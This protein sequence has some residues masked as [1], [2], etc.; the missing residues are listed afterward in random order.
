MLKALALSQLVHSS[1]GEVIA[2]LQSDI[3]QITSF[4]QQKTTAQ[5]DQNMTSYNLLGFALVLRPALLAPVTT[6]A[7]D[8]LSQLALSEAFQALDD[9]RQA[10]LEYTR[11]G[12]ALTPDIL[13]GV[14]E[15]ARWSESLQSLQSKTEEWLNNSRETRFRYEPITKVWKR[16]LNEGEPLSQMLTVVIQDDRD[17][18]QQVEQ[19]INAFSSADRVHQLLH[20][21]DR[22]IRGRIADVRAIDNAARTAVYR[23]VQNAL[24]FAQDWLDLLQNEPQQVNSFIHEQANNCRTKIISCLQQSQT[25]LQAFLQQHSP[26]LE[27]AASVATVN[28]A[29][30]DL[31][32]LFDP[33][34][35][36]KTAISWQH[37]LHA[38]LLRIPRLTLDE[39]WQRPAKLSHR[40]FLASLLNLLQ[41]EQS[42]DWDKAFDEQCEVGNHLATQRIIDILK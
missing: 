42:I 8:L 27:L 41:T 23:H 38:E 22:E 26:R 11:L 10:I 20:R 19:T 40:E 39:T 33:Q 4:F 21:T 3:P 28:R 9:L 31:Q 5:Y 12:L 25:Q 13:K 29:L 18:Q 15:Q 7:T 1:L 34:Q 37:V 16:W 17:K 30:E 14:G 24:Q 2:E 6:G 32:A 35:T 36:E